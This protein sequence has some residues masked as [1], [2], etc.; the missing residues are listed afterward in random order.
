MKS[1]HPHNVIITSYDFQKSLCPCTAPRCPVDRQ[2]SRITKNSEG[3]S[4][5]TST[6]GMIINI[7]NIGLIIN[8]I[9]I[10]F[11]LIKCINGEKATYNTGVFSAKRE[12]TFQVCFDYDNDDDDDDDGDDDD[13]DV[14]AGAA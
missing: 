13:E 6:I 2:D 14:S 1:Y 8:I 11:L 9:N 7:I 4:V 12:R 10:R 5:I 3:Q